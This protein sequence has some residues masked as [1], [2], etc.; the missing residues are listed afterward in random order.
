MPAAPATSGADQGQDDRV[1]A[2]EYVALRR[3]LI[4]DVSPADGQS[5]GRGRDNEP[6]ARY[7]DPRTPRCT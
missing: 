4:L 6:D 3:Q 7:A 1:D 2:G 5:E